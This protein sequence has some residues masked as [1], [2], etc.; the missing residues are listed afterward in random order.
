MA[1]KIKTKNSESTYRQTVK[2]AVES[3]KNVVKVAQEYEAK[4]PDKNH[5]TSAMI[6]SGQTPLLEALHHSFTFVED[7]YLYISSLEK[8]CAELDKTR[9][10]GI[11]DATRKMTE[12]PTKQ[13]EEQSKKDTGYIK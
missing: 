1:L 5:F 12:K 9:W 8:Y 4:Q 3:A 6:K 2:E 13:Q 10:K 11:M 7:L